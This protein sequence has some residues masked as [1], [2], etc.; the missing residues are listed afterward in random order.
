MIINLYLGTYNFYKKFYINIRKEYNK[1]IPL[2]I[3][4][5]ENN[6]QILYCINHLAILYSFKEH[7]NAIERLNNIID[8]ETDTILLFLSNNAYKFKNNLLKNFKINQYYID[9]EIYSTLEHPLLSL[10]NYINNQNFIFKNILKALIN[11][12]TIEELFFNLKYI[13][14]LEFLLSKLLNDILLAYS[15]FENNIEYN[16]FKIYYKGNI[17]SLLIY[18]FI[19][20][21]KIDI[22]YINNLSIKLLTL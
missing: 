18:K 22:N 1:K 19:S 12:L 5:E 13:N 11:K 14:G 15:I 4:L 20:N 3:N 10:T 7:N 6:L 8:Y 9:N 2:Y 17:N 16:Q 21:E